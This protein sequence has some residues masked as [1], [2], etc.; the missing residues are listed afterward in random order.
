MSVLVK[1]H[2]LIIIFCFNFA[3]KPFAFQKSNW[4]RRNKRIF[5]Q[6]VQ[7]MYGLKIWKSMSAFYYLLL[8]WTGRLGLQ[9]SVINEPKLFVKSISK[10]RMRHVMPDSCLNPQFHYH[11]T[12]VV[13]G[14]CISNVHWTLSDININIWFKVTHIR[15]FDHWI[16][17]GTSL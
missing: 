12:H 16:W 1:K 9:C 3:P 7:N 5:S 6:K 8:F 10:W 17:E 11:T 15:S 2:K 14:S 13:L 4:R